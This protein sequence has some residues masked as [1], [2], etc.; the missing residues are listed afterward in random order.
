MRRLDEAARA[1]AGLLQ[2]ARQPGDLSRSARRTL[3]RSIHMLGRLRL[4]ESRWFGADRLLAQ[5]TLMQ[6]GP[7]DE[8]E[9]YR[10]KAFDATGGSLAW[11][12]RQ[13]PTA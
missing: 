8:A 7:R 9:G 1:L 12:P 2:G 4:E 11:T 5:A 10:A 3:A 13:S 6:L